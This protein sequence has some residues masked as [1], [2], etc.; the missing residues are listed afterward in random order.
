MSRPLPFLPHIPHLRNRLPFCLLFRCASLI[1]LLAIPELCHAD[2]VKLMSGGELRG[3][4]IHSSDTKQ[5]IR[6]ETLTG[7]IVVVERDQTHFVTMRSLASEEYETR[8]RRIRDTWQEHWELSEWCRQHGLTKP[9]EIHLRRVIELSPDHEKAQAAL[10]RVWHQGAWIDRDELM[11]SQGYVKY[12]NKYITPQELE[13]IEKTTEELERERG[14]F[15]KVRLWHGWLDGANEDR[16][17]KAIVE[18]KAIDDPHAATAIVKFVCPDP[19][20]EVR[21]LSVD[22]LV[23]ISGH[24]A[25]AGL[26]KMALFDE[27][28]QVRSAALEG[29]GRDYYQHAQNAFA[30]ELKSDYNAV[31]CR[32]ATALGRIGDKKIVGSL[33]DALITVHQYQVV[34]DVPVSPTYSFTTDGN[35]G[36]NTAALP[37]SVMAAVRTGQM[38][39]PVMAP[40]NDFIPKKTVTVRVEHYNEDVLNALVKLTQQNFGYDRRTWNLWWAA[41]KHSGGKQPK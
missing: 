7:A 27:A 23:K 28:T 11:A 5:K 40:S 1:C 13:V 9:R 6:L 12:K 30:K 17:R 26:V 25:V 16:S 38:L 24:K 3:K 21:G 15:Q 14:W 35:F 34:S 31:V 18:F 22:V 10:G 41:E 32:A 19:R 37:P 39:P 20:V 8:T 36:S 4:I 33:I 29:I 2:L